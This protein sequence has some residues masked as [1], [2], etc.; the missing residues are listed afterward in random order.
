MTFEE[1]VAVQY[2][3]HLLVGDGAIEFG[4][5]RKAVSVAFQQAPEHP[6]DDLVI[7]AARPGNQEPSL[8]LALAVRRSPNLVQSNRRTR[9]LIQSFVK[10]VINTPNDGMEHHLG[11]VTAGPKP[12]C[13]E[14][15]ELADL[16]AV[17]IDAAEFFKLVRTPNKFRKSIRDRLYHLEQLVRSALI[18]LDV[19]EPNAAVVEHRTWQLLARLVVL[20]PRLESPDQTD[21]AAVTNS[22]VKVSRTSDLTGAESLRS[23]LVELAGEYSPKSAVVDLSLLKRDAHVMLNP[24]ARRHREAWRVLDHLQEM[25]LKSVRYEVASIDGLRTVKLD[26]SDVARDLIAKAW[27]TS[28]L[29]V[30]G[31]SGVGKSALTLRA[32][33]DDSAKDPIS[34]QSL[35]INLR[36]VPKLTIEFEEKLGISLAS[37]LSELSAPE[38]TLIIDGA[39]A[40]TEGLEDAFRYMV[41]AAATSGVKIVAVTS[42]DSI[43]VVRDILRDRFGARVPEHIVKPLTDGELDEIVTTFTELRKLNANP[44]SRDLLRR[45]VVVALLVRGDLTGVPLSDADAM[46]E[47]WSQLVRRQE[48]S[49]RGLPD[50]REAVL[51]QLAA[52]SLHGSE[53]LDIIASLDKTALAGLR[54]DGLLQPSLED[55]Y[56]IGPDFAHDEVRR[57]AVARL[58][59]AER[60]PASRILKGGGPRW[61]L[62]AARLACQALLQERDK[63]DVPLP[64]RFAALQTSFDALVEAGHGVRWGDVPSEALLTIADP[65]PVL[66]DA[67]PCFGADGDVGLQR[68]AR[69]VNQRLRG[70]YGFIDPMA[71]EPIVALLLE[72]HA[73]WQ[74][75]DHVCLLLREWLQGHLIARS[76]AGNPMR[77]LLRERLVAAAAE[78]DHRLA[79]RNEAAASAR[80]N[81]TKEDIERERQFSES[82]PDLF[83][84]IGFGGRQRRQRPEVPSECTDENF[85]ELMALLGPDLGDEGEAILGRIAN[86]APWEL[87]PAVDEPLSGLGLAN[88]RRGLLARLVQAYY[89][90]DETDGLAPFDNGIRDHRSEARHLLSPPAAWHYGPF[91]ALLRSDLRGGVATLNRLLNH[92]ALTRAR[93]LAGLDMTNQRLEDIDIG[94]YREHLEV[95][96]VRRLYIGDSHVWRWYRGTG[97]GPYPCISALQALERMCD[98]WIKAGVSL[99]TLVPLLLDGCENLAMAGLVVGILFRHLESADDLLDPFLA[100]PL[101]WNYEFERMVHEHSGLAASSEGIEASERRKWSPRDAAMFMAL[102]AEGGRVDDLRSLGETLVDRVRHRIERRQDSGAPE[103][104]MSHGKDIEKELASVRAWA[105]SLDRD[106][107]QV[108]EREGDLYVEAIPPEEVT[109]ALQHSDEDLEHAAEHIRLMNRYFVNLEESHIK[110][111]GSKEITADLA[112]ARKLLDNPPSLSASHS[113]DVPT[114]VAA[115]AL[116]AHLLHDVDLPDEA[117]IFAADTV[118]RVSEGAAGPR[119]YEFEETYFEQGAE[120]SAARALPTLL[121]PDAALLRSNIDRADGSSTLH[122]AANACLN[123]AH[124]KANEVRLHLARGLDCLWAAPCTQDGV[125]H[126]EIGLQLAA[127]MMRDSTISVE[128]PSRGRSAFGR[129]LAAAFRHSRGTASELCRLIAH[130]LSLLRKG[131]CGRDGTPLWRFGPQPVTR[132][133]SGCTAI[134]EIRPLGMP[135]VVILQD[136]LADSLANTADNSILPSRL[137]ASIRALAPAAVANICISRPAQELLTVLFTAQRRSLLTDEQGRMDHRGSH[138]LVSA[139]ALLTLA[140]RG[141]DAT[142]FE[143][144]NAYSQ[145]SALLGNLLSALSATAEEAPSRAAEAKRL[146]PKIVRH[147][148]NLHA[149]NRTAF[150]EDYYGD[151]A[152]AALLPN[153]AS[154]NQYL[155]RELQKGPITW[156]DPLAMQSEVEEW[157]AI[158]IAKAECVDQLIGFLRVLTPEQQARTGLPWMVTLVLP[159][160]GKIAKRSFLLTTWLIDT[161]AAAAAVGLSSIW[162][163]IVDALVVEGIAQLAPYS[164]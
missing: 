105:S 75:G 124:A 161:R 31:E 123:L 9:E 113:W 65:G 14:L 156:W 67:W 33:S 21:W 144:I 53:R 132:K 36:H 39:D 142:V 136:P 37:P 101:V 44:R 16:A 122:L 73:P 159:N 102:R 118:V 160:P 22:L 94:P 139:R 83:S 7:S 135:R 151:R 60:D 153:P 92:A 88:Y 155:Y 111:I 76:P 12:H 13:Q 143:F 82:Y 56:L 62:G 138:T 134:G 158:A 70:D 29:L 68:L 110:H 6:V 108:H 64:G 128:I 147:V 125:C 30:G 115:S 8:E 24:D 5:G 47:V 162:Q 90:D 81:R 74:S 141:D 55:P 148:L 35:I 131:L 18:E 69:L 95:T 11:L 27:G 77:T 57:Y 116:R 130:R 80:A 164:D 149:S 84:E 32:F 63:D 72:E 120:R 163:Q 3:A 51:L 61:I 121:M 104:E 137:D 126:H 85:L 20:M 59:V 54:Q 109:E 100:E 49:D 41:D 23:R 154:D 42:N 114:L 4:V 34:S 157:L 46:R 89:L 2:L 127:E 58:L 146:W 71:I 79:K 50:M 93:T 91:M 106:R 43:A 140:Q 129:A 1:R 97:V 152:L 150:E 103:L 40:A 10:A 87:A 19:A 96:G 15:A 145:D 117:S 38:R 26:R 107:F 28:V 25:A 78:A 99:R 52:H 17:Q 112:S 133:I 119:P 45:L 48:K 66:Q 86:D 98:E